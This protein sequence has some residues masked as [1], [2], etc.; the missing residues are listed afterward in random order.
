MKI[1][2]LGGTGLLGK[3]LQKIDSNLECYGSDVDISDKSILFTKL[4]ELQPDIILHLAAVKDSV[5][6]DNNPIETIQT[7]I[8]GTANVSMWCCENNCRLVFVSTDYVYDSNLKTQH[9]ESEGTKPFNLYAQS[10]LGGECSVSFVKNH[11]I[12]RTSFGDSKFPYKSVYDN[13]YVS[14]DY[15]DIIAPMIYK[16]VVSD[17]VG[18]INV[19]TE[20]KTILQYARRR[21]E[22]TAIKHIQSKNFILNTTRYNELF[23]S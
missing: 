5:Y 6:V 13:L 20:P 12:I 14:K 16:V 1:V 2:V 10:K 19:G 17:Y 21:N 9:I 7:N 15:V 18:I 3:E 8:I 22:I 4:N 23:N 11:C